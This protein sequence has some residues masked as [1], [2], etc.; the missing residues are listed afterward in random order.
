[1]LFELIVLDGIRYWLDVHGTAWTALVEVGGV[2]LEPKHFEVVALHMESANWWVVTHLLRYILEVLH[3]QLV[4]L[5][6]HRIKGLLG[7]PLD[8]VVHDDAVDG[9]E[10]ESHRGVGCDVRCSF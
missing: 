1:M 7:P 10:S 5:T 9:A 6:Q 2:A 3:D 4:R 8:V